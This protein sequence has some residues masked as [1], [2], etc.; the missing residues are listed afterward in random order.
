MSNNITQTERLIGYLDGEMNGD[1]KDLLQKDL[2][3]DKSLQQELDNLLLAT[4]VV[5]NYGLRGKVAGIHKEMMNEI[6]AAAVKQS[7]PV[8]H[9]AKRIM[10]YAAGIILLVVM[11]G[12]YQYFSVSANNLYL[13]EYSQYTVAQ[14]RGSETISAIEKAFLEKKYDEVIADFNRL[15][16]A[17][18]KDYFLTGQAYLIKENYT[19]AIS[20]FKTVLK[21]NTL[22]NSGLLFDDA[23]YYLALSFLKNNEIN[24]A[25]RL[26][27]KIYHNKEH[28][29]HD[30]VSGLFL[31]KLQLLKWKQ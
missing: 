3:A 31:L 17:S 30:N 24:D 16:D 22:T 8:R 27:K 14:F 12:L 1:E 7:A 21:K 15:S 28:L 19:S 4:E 11:F 29:Y 26:F 25:M 6:A 2:K 23:E 10:K 18:V 20:S 5:K 9:L 13:K